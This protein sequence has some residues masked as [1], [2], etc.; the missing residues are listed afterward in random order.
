MDIALNSPGWCR[1]GARPSRGGE[2]GITATLP[3]L[4]GDKKAFT[5]LSAPGIFLTP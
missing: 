4:H 5:G 2:A 3:F 1:S